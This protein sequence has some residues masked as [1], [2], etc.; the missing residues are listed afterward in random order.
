MIDVNKLR[1]PKEKFYFTVAA[2][3]GGLVWLG[4]L[5]GTMGM[6]LIFAAMAAVPLWIAQQFFKAE[7][8]GNAVRVSERQY[9]ELHKVV[10]QCAKELGLKEVPDV[11]VT[12]GG[13]ALNALAIKFIGRQYVILYAELVDLMLSQ[14]R[15]GELHMVVAHELAHHAAGHTDWKKNLLMWPAMWMPYIGGAY[16]R[17]CEFTAD[18]LGAAVVGDLEAAKRALVML[19]AGTTTLRT[20]I[21]AFAQQE[22]EIPPFFGYI[23]EVYATHPRMTRRVRELDDLEGQ[24]PRRRATAQLN[25][26]GQLGG[27]RQ[28]SVA[29]AE[30]QPHEEWVEG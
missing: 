7:V 18:R 26:T 23:N 3:V 21:K 22:A 20:D 10:R 30:Q 9:P 14:Q 2:A 27:A 11:F 19:A 8:Y 25:A 12:S 17:A 24:L 4:L 6:V 28:A 1:H 16:G 5:L 29:A 15:V 13:G